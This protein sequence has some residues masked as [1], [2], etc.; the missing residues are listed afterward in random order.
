M[1]QSKPST[2]SVEASNR[3]A[4]MRVAVASVRRLFRLLDTFDQW[5][6]PPGELSIAFLDDEEMVQLHADFLDDPTPTDVITFPG[7]DGDGSFAGE[8]CVCIPQAER[9]AP[10]HGTTVAE[11]IL[12]YLVHGWLHLAGHDDL[13]EV[14]RAAMRVAEQETL[15]FLSGRGFLPEWTKVRR[16]RKP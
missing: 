11:E 16:K 1:P 12:L 7:E 13:S 10:K 4:R 3:S 9:E 15:A 6:I 2:R 5:K 14:P 8:I